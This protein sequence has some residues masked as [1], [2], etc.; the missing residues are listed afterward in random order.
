M[1]MP[2]PIGPIVWLLRQVSSTDAANAAV[3][4]LLDEFAARTEAGDVPRSPALWMNVQSI[5]VALSFAMSMMPRWFRSGSYMIRDAARSLRR[6]PAYSLLVI[7][8]LGVGIAAGT[9]TYS[10]VDAVVLKPLAI[11][12]G[13][14]VVVIPTR[15]A[16]APFTA[17]ISADGFH[18]IQDAVTGLEAVAATTMFS[19]DTVTIGTST[20]SPTVLHTTAGLFRVLRFGPMIGRI[21][22]AD[23]EKRGETDGAVLG[24]RFWREKLQGDPNVLGR[25]VALG[26][27]TFSVIGVLAPDTDI[28]D[29][30]Y[31]QCGVWVP[32]K[33]GDRFSLVGRMRPDVSPKRLADEIQAV[34]AIA[35]WRP[36]VIPLL[37][38]Y[39]SRFRDWMLLALGAAGLIVLI[40]CVNAAN[41]MLTRSFRRAQELAI[42][43]S[44]GASRRHIALSVMTEG[45]VLSSV[46][47][48]C[49]LLFSVW[50]IAVARSAVTATLGAIYRSAQIQL[51]GRVLVVAISAAILTGIF[52]SLVP[53]WQSSRASVVGVL[54]DTGP[55][56][57]G[58]GRKW[59]SGL[60]IAEIGCVTVLLVVSWLFLSSLIRVAGIDLGIDRSHLLAI[61]SN[62]EFNGTVDDIRHRVESLPGITG[63]A[64][65]YGGASLP[66]IGRAF[67]GVWSTASIERAGSAA[68]HQPFEMLE[69]RVT[70][71]YFDVAGIRLR[72]GSTWAPEPAIDTTSVVLDEKAAAQLFGNEEALGQQVRATRSGVAREFT[73][74]GIVQH[75]YARGPE[76]PDLPGAYFAMKPSATR[77]FA[78][79]FVR[80]SRPADQMLSAVTDAIASFA[81]PAMLY[82]WVQAADDAVGR[83]TAVRRFNGWLMSAFGLVAML[84]G[85]AGIYGVIAAIVA[86][87]TREIGVRVALGATP[88][89]IR[90]TVLRLAGAHVAAGLAIGL[91]AAWWF[92]RGFAAYL[93]QVTP[94]DVSVYVVVAAMVS[95]VALAAAI[96]PARRAARTDPMITLRS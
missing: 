23:D 52:A 66:L 38:T 36:A 51:N 89:R 11:E 46:A 61:S 7:A 85:A 63:V 56:V 86:Q 53:A 71:N 24:Y 4:D 64:V 81:P 34:L 60:L 15:E 50:G 65:S 28:P 3:G 96:I 37:D 75:V 48:A 1:M 29:L 2:Q 49:A 12:R 78:G 8:L 74:V 93:F 40:A 47:S 41:I 5:K 95:G 22:T 88:A 43:S 72:R 55:T 31:S 80:T 90:R 20:E 59:R 9:I 27:R 83:I 67:S 54:K 35:D 25:T 70:A 73:V 33:P 94:A 10:V 44:L 69:F 68:G 87:Q 82:P 79:L 6:S 84:I 39:T 30:Q 92:S 13:D 18:T 19:G 42:R 77:N 14:R 16:V 45:L 91:P 17:R 76:D 57:T 62:R 58:G 26:S 32:L 21:W